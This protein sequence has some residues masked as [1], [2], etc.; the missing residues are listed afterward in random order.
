MIRDF[1]RPP[2]RQNGAALLFVLACAALFTICLYARRRIASHQRKING[3]KTS[4]LSQ[5][6]AKR[7]FIDRIV[8]QAEKEKAPLSEAERY[9][10]N[11]TEIEE[12]FKI[13]DRLN[14]AFYSETTDDEYEKKVGSLLKHA[15]EAD[16]GADRNMKERYVSAYRALRDRDHYILIIIKDA[17]GSKLQR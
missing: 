10:L 15:Y 5:F 2:Q 7:F 3:G 9:M 8:A 12:G 6:E 13:D 4:S 17:L 1:L 14:S 11:W 16:A